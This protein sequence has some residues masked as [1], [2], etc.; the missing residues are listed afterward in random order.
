[1]RPDGWADPLWASGADDR[2]VGPVVTGAEVWEQLGIT[3]RVEWTLIPE[4]ERLAA[5][6]PGG[7][8]PGV[9]IPAGRVQ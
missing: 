4:V 1:M 3:P 8:R 6:R 9:G 2:S 7:R 5:G